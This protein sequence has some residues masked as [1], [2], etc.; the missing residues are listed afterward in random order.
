MVSLSSTA[1]KLFNLGLVKNKDEA[2][3]IFDGFE[4]DPQI[5]Y[6]FWCRYFDLAIL[7]LALSKLAW[8]VG[9]KG[10]RFDAKG[11]V[12]MWI[13]RSGKKI[14]PDKTLMRKI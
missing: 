14:T 9:Q 8:E 1:H 4:C 2:L 3:K 10:K 6:K 5:N 7:K 12:M 13:K 11:S